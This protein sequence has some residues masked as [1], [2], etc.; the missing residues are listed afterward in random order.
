[1]LMRIVGSAIGPVVAAMFMESYQ[2]SVVIGGRIGGGAAIIESYPSAESYDL[3]YLTCALLTLFTVGLALTLARTTPKCQKHLPKERGEMRGA[4]VEAMKREI[5][6]WPNVTSQPHRFGGID[7]RVG[8]KEMGHLH[9]ENMVDLPL[10]P[11][12][13]LASSSNKL[14]GLPKQWE[15]KT[16]GSLPPHDAYPESNWINYWIKGEDDVP[17]VVALFRLQYDRLTKVTN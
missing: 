13:L 14:M 9:G 17:R 3:I 5:M 4:I 2:Y 15:E 8:G 12:A 11:N 7:F 16:Q 6:S 10:P 1:M